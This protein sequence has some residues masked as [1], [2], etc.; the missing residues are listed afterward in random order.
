LT[1]DLKERLKVTAE[2]GAVVSMVMPD[3]PAFRAGLKE[4]DVITAVDNQEVKTAEELRDAIQKAGPGKEVTLQ[5]L[6]GKDK[7]A[8]KA[9]LQEGVPSSFF[10]P[11]PDRMTP[12]DVESPF[13][14]GRK[15]REL[16]RKIQELENR[17]RALEKK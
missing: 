4:D 12:P 5:V 17:V 11:G 15:I 3:S 8:I 1:P 7:L 14:Q 2:R 16:E 6:R 10:P 13:N 9:K